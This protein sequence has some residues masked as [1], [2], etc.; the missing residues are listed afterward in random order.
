MQIKKMCL[1]RTHMANKIVVE[2]SSS[3]QDINM[4]YVKKI[5]PSPNNFVSSSRGCTSNLENPCLVF[6]SLQPF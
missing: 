3:L 1:F 4:K 6:Y 2:T 5:D